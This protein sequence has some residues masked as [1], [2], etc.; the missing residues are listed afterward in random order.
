MLE[1]TPNGDIVVAQFDPSGTG[2]STQRFDFTKAPG[3]PHLEDHRCAAFDGLETNSSPETLKRA[4]SG[5]PVPEHLRPADAV[6]AHPFRPRSGTTEDFLMRDE[7]S[8]DALTFDELAGALKDVQ[9][10]Q[11]QDRCARARCLLHVHGWLAA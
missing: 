8:A 3:E 11:Q 1:G 2:V 4:S 7:A 10:I 6:A 5:G 9:R